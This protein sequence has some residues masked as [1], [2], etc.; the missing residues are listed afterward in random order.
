MKNSIILK[1][2]QI[3]GAC[4]VGVGGKIGRDIR[5]AAKL[6]E[7]KIKITKEVLADKNQKLNKIK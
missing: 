6:S 4:G 7:K 2:R 3:I 1:N 5:L